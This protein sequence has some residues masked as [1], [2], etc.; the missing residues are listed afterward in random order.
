MKGWGTAATEEKKQSD[1]QLQKEIKFIFCR[2]EMWLKYVSPS[3]AQPSAYKFMSDAAINTS[4]AI[5]FGR[6]WTIE[7]ILDLNIRKLHL[8]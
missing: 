6:N 4:I 3:L 7:C 1:E 2:W 8:R 5:K